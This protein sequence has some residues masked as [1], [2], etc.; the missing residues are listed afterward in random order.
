MTVSQSDFNAM[1]HMIQVFLRGAAQME[2]I[3]A[4][5]NNIV[6]SLENGALVSE[7]GTRLCGILQNETIPFTARARIKY[8]EL[9]RDLDGVVQ[10]LRDGDPGARSR[11]ES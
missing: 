10:I 11:F 2:A 5:L 9:S 3:T 8:Q 4:A 6:A 1:E 7:Q